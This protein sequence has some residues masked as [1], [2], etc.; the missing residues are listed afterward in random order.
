[1]EVGESMKELGLKLHSLFNRSLRYFV[2]STIMT[3]GVCFIML[4]A[5]LFSGVM[6]SLTFYLLIFSI[7]DVV[8]TLAICIYNSHKL[9]VPINRKLIK[10][11]NEEDVERARE[12]NRRR[13][14]RTNH[15]AS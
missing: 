1:M 15:K 11:L 8:L 13:N 7:F 12:F 9:L 5:N 10:K 14:R 6:V 3:F 2:F 4:I